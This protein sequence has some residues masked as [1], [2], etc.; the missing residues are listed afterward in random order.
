MQQLSDSKTSVADAAAERWRWA[1]LALCGL[2]FFLI[3]VNIYT[4]THLN[5]DIGYVATH[6]RIPL[7]DLV[8]VTPGGDAARSGMQT[9]DLVDVARLDPNARF[10]LYD[11]I[12]VNEPVVFAVRR[13]SRDLTVAVI[14]K[15]VL[16]S[17]WTTWLS[18]AGEAW[19]TLFCTILAWRRSS[20]AAGALVLY[21]LLTLVIAQGFGDVS[22]PWPWF[23]F[24]CLQVKGALFPLGFVFIAVY[25]EQFA[26]PLSPLRRGLTAFTFAMAALAVAFAQW[27]YL[28]ATRGRVD[29][30]VPLLLIRASPLS[31]FAYV[32]LLLTVL[33][34]LFAALRVSRGHERTRL[35]WGVSGIA[36]FLIWGIVV[37]VAGESIP[38][39]SF[40]AISAACW[41]V[42]P[43]ILTYSLVNQRLFDIGFIVNRA[44]VFTG[45][46]IVVLG[47]FTL[48]EWLLSDW[49][50]DASHTTNLLVGG[51]LALALGLSIRAV[52]G[53]VDRAVDNV[54]FRQRHEDEQAIRTFA[55]EVAYIGDRGILLERAAAVL[56]G[57]TNA[58]SIE[59][60][61]R[62]DENDPAIVRMRAFPQPVDLHGFPSSLRG[63]IAFPMAARGRFIGAVVLG[64]RTS[65]ETYA[66]DEI[67]AISLLAHNVASALDALG[68]R[69]GD[70][71]TDRIIDSIEALRAEIVR[72][73][74]P[75][76]PDTVA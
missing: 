40:T 23:D 50:R 37:A 24:F 3:A 64:A 2:G 17:N 41:F 74:P 61:L 59:I 52:H 63:D 58:V 16:S 5:A 8:T 69:N 15:H 51:G 68:S 20:P 6:T 26:R 46:S 34:T 53:R 1:L 27:F 45:V 19:I 66:P 25:A 65:G 18:Y 73:L 4:D 49:L 55:H 57:H 21:L 31:R 32:F 36:P 38:F 42:T 35:I 13:G 75:V 9:G 54:F 48:V 67:S 33:A 7:V 60:V 14:P 70:S 10:R 30:F 22:T 47:T 28:A 76:E 12:R 44:A 72:R 56:E 11:G 29:P 62:Y 39:V 43:A 71:G